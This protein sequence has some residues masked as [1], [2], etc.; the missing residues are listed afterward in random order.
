MNI[1]VESCTK[2]VDAIIKKNSKTLK[3]VWLGSELFCYVCSLSRFD[4]IWF[5]FLIEICLNVENGLGR[6]GA[7]ALADVIK[8]CELLEQ[9]SVTGL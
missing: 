5:C 1:S 7:V 9:L 6:Q 2:F 8:N 3:Y 4:V